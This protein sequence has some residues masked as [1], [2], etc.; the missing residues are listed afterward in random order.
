VEKTTSNVLEAEDI[1][2]YERWELP[3]VNGPSATATAKELQSIQKQAYDE[4]FALGEKEAFEQTK[5]ELDMNAA[6]MRSIIEVLS[7]PLKELDDDIVHQLSELSMAVARQVI[8]RELHTE[9]GEIVGIVREAMNALPASTRKITLNIHPEDAE[10]IR[11]AF[12]LGDE[13]DSD[14]L[15]WKVIEDPM[16]TRGG[17]K[18]F[19]ENSRIDATVDARLNRVISTLLGGE[20]ESD[21]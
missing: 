14:E 5:Q 13:S 15:R 11:N 7:E 20:R 10:L 2:A 9:Q 12:S 6:S 16:I 21:E 4:G 17:C 1:T 3:L 8:R 19:S 18:I